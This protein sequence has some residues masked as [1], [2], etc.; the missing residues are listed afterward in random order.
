MLSG[1]ASLGWVED[2]RGKVLR[3]LDFWVDGLRISRKLASRV[4]SDS[5]LQPLH[6][7]P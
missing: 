3:K 2:L 4:G 5:T 6:G 1:G 7:K